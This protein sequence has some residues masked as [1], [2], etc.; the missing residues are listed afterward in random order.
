MCGITGILYS[1]SDSLPQIDSEP[2]AELVSKLI[3]EPAEP[4]EP[5]VQLIEELELRLA[6]LREYSAFAAAWSDE[7]LRLRL[8][9]LAER[10][11]KYERKTHSSLLQANPP[12]PTQLIE[13]WNAL[14]IRLRDAAWLIKQDFLANID[15][16]KLIVPEELQQAPNLNAWKIT[17][18]INNI[19]RLEVR[20]RDSLGISVAVT[21]ENGEAYAAF[22]KLLEKEGLLEELQSR[23]LIKDLSNLSI[24][25]AEGEKPGL[26]FVYKVSQEVGA[27][28]DNAAAIR[29][30]L[31]EDR[32]LWLALEQPRIFT[33]IWSHTR[34]ASN[35]VISL[36]NCHPVDEQ[37]EGAETGDYWIAAAL[38]GDI[39]NFQTILA[40]IK[41]D[42]GNS[43]SPRI[44]TDAKS[45][46]VL[47]DYYYRRTGSLQEAFLKSVREFEGSVSICLS[48]SLQPNLTYLAL[49]GSGQS[50]FVGLCR[51]GYIFASEMY[52]L[53]EQT[54]RY[55]RMDGTYEAVPGDSEGLGQI[56]VIDQNKTGLEGIRAFS[57]DGAP[58]PLTEKNIRKAEITTRDINRGEHSHFLLK[59]IFDAPDSISKTLQGKYYIPADFAE[60]AS[61]NLGP[62]VFPPDLSRKFADNL[63][64]RILLIGQGTAAVAGS[65]VASMMQRALKGSGIEVRAIKATELSGYAM[66]EDMSQT[67]IIAVSQSGTTTDTNRTVDMVR[68]NKA[69][70]I[71]IVNRRNSDLT[72]KVDG[73]M[74]TSDGRDI[75]MSVASTKA[76]YS[77]VIAGYL[78][79]LYIAKQMKTMDE[80][81]IRRELQEM[82]D[83][84]HKIAVL[85]D[86]RSQVEKL[87]RQYATTR[88]DWA[89]VGSGSTRAAAEEIRIKLSELC[90]KSIATDYIEDK[91]H[92]DLSSEPLTLICTAGLPGMALQDS[93]KEVA[94]FK[95]HKSIPIVIASESFREFEKYAAGIIYV[96][97]ASANASV[98][99]NTV[100][101]HLWG[102]YCALAINDGANLLKAGRAMAIQHLSSSESPIWTQ[103]GIRRLLYIGKTF[104][105]DLK[106][107]R[108]NSSLSV[109]SAVRLS[110]MFQYFSG[111][112]SLRQFAQDFKG[113]DLIET[114]VVCLSQGIQELSRP[115][116]AIKHQAKTITVGISRS[117]EN[118]SGPVFEALGKVDLST[119]DLP[120]RDLPMLKALNIA[121]E[122]VLG[123]TVY[124]IYGFSALNEVEDFTK[125]KVLQKHGLAKNLRSRSEAEIP[126][127][128]TKQWV[129]ANRRS[130]VGHGRNDSRPIL[131]IPIIS[132]GRV[133]YLV[134]LHLRF[135]EE[136][137]LGQR[138]DVIK[139]LT[140]RYGD[141]VSQ[142]EET[143]LI[144]RDEFLNLL[145]VEE[146]STERAAALA[147]LIIKRQQS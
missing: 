94:I 79:G 63:I 14:W 72:Y 137:P 141:L 50:L 120:Y 112:R 138:L 45:I 86:K 117:A 60:E 44:T 76:F 142:I 31:R 26:M 66:E 70:V 3:S 35:G 65:A 73:V 131:I 140:N 9:E 48:S 133:D 61:I 88:R 39:D 38:N 4:A 32:L 125:I 132:G 2:I 85:L 10:L 34:W 83:L 144:W 145:S 55:L 139:N 58:L 40:K 107:G 78:L 103:S 100:V 51:H 52:G 105:D 1:C 91:K 116:D 84:P 64:N 146:L 115:I 109:D 71:A 104:Q 8:A 56:F 30:S 106:E 43:V 97:D 114:M 147:E 53:V 87:A 111:A 21:F 126:L 37:L 101:G 118:I 129:A 46:P 69:T 27:L 123:I 42:S 12:L 11:L 82:V 135:K 68:A 5:P 74:Y 47:V 77:Q 136:L 143:N 16:V 92:I 121:V 19:D 24:R 62:E 25:S 54:D 20:G 29:K 23:R 18:V 22:M 57:A 134:L 81:E 33:N 28:G 7:P 130:Y 93:V 96:P 127:V 90:Y 108:F 15:R 124:G 122:Q 119:E 113:N 128:G 75:E 89:V 13:K 17:A 36:P 67:L 102:Y 80:S 41:E 110:L 98:L 99:L 6:C 95:S 49:K 59:E